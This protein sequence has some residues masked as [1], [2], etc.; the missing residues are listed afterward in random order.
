MKVF[1][2]F[3]LNR[4]NLQDEVLKFLEASDLP[5]AKLVGDKGV[6]SENHKNF[7]GL[8]M[9]PNCNDKVNEFVNRCECALMIG[10][11]QSDVNTDAFDYR[12]PNEK[13]GVHSI[14]KTLVKIY[15]FY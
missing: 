12:M 6:I 7:V 8:Y 1:P 14:K 4:Y 13:V 10:T 9:G 3:L 11:L 5:F 15:N 2:G